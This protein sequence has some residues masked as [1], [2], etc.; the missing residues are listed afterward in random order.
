MNIK[1]LR[2]QI[3][4]SRDNGALTD[5]NKIIENYKLLS[6]SRVPKVFIEASVKEF[7]TKHKLSESKSNVIREHVTAI[8][9]KAG[10]LGY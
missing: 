4:D 3:L 7:A 1:Q 5:A 6:K 10:K 8:L 2:D 9:F